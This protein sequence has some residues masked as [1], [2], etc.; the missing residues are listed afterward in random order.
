MAKYTV[1]YQY[2]YSD[3]VHEW[4]TENIN[5]AY[6]YYNDM[7]KS[8]STKKCKLFKDKKLVTEYQIEK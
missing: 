2:T 3:Q 7:C 1:K 8:I 5:D 4:T 6:I